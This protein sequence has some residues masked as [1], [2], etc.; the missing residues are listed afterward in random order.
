[1]KKILTMAMIFFIS[2]CFLCRTSLAE[3]YKYEDNEGVTRFTKNQRSME[4]LN[5]AVRLNPNDARA[6]S[7]RGA[8]YY[9]L[10]QHQRAIDDCN[11]AIRLKPD[12]TDAY[13][14]RGIAYDGLGQHKLAIKDLNKAISLQPDL[15]AAYNNR[16]IVYLKQGNYSLACP[17]A[18]KACELGNCFALQFAKSSELCLTK[19]DYALS[20]VIKGDK[21]TDNGQFQR[22][23]EYYNQAILLQPNA[24]YAYNSR[25]AAYILRGN[26]KLGC[27]DAQKACE[28]G[29]CKALKF[30]KSMGACR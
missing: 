28:L 23:L 11:E 2:L 22:A 27:R 25:G 21:L 9:N 12:Y 15:V 30:G 19:Q 16:S 4:D 7:Y 10:G 14:N 26:Y 1:M 6:Y 29:T 5:E 13:V 18:H 20:Y 8:A 24:A 17:D 3:I